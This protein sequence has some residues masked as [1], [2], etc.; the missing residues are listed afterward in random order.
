MQAP[1]GLVGL[2]AQDGA[3]QT[4]DKIEIGYKLRLHLRT[5]STV[6]CHH[7]TANSYVDYL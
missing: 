5:P 2:N 3:C 4:R 1:R 6:T 7:R